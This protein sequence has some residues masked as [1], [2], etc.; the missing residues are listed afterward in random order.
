MEGL[1]DEMFAT[2]K[3]TEGT[4]G[5]M[6]SKAKK[7][8]SQQAIDR[9]LR[10]MDELPTICWQTVFA[11]EAIKRFEAIVKQRFP[12]GAPVAFQFIGQPRADGSSSWVHG[13][14]VVSEHQHVKQEMIYTGLAVEVD[15]KIASQMGVWRKRLAGE[16]T[17]YLV[18][19]SELEFGDRP[20]L[21]DQA[22]AKSG[23]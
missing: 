8:K 11:M 7:T 6:M 20:L 15:E 18:T 2:T 16:K 10:I 23:A 19:W 17:V 1:A 21:P 12:R 9:A 22:I 3:D 13:F 4:K 14:G 5:T